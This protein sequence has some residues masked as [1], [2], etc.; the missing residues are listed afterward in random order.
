MYRHGPDRTIAPFLEAREEQACIALLGAYDVLKRDV[1][2]LF[3]YIEPVASNL[4]VYSQRT[5][6]LLLRACTEVEACC[7]NILR[8]NGKSTDG[9]DM[10]RYSDLEAPMQLSFYEVSVL[11]TQ[12]PPLR[13]FESFL[14][15]IRSQRSP[16]W[17]RAYNAVKHD[18]IGK[19]GE[20]RLEN[21]LAAMA[22]LHVLLVAQYGP[23]LSSTIGMSPSG[24]LVNRGDL[25]RERGLPSWVPDEGYDY[26]WSTL[27][28]TVEPYAHHEIPPR[29]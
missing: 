2:R 17:Y 19:F 9:T 14:N 20:A 29:P 18:R 8:A 13:P 16:P 7:K 26:D 24:M 25:L 5:F 27:K 12:L 21:V 10:L 3:E 1:R 23:G 11:R 28:N 22:G 4:S 6:E 15:V